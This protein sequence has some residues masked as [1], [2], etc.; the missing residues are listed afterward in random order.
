MPD[1]LSLL[2]QVKEVFSKRVDNEGKPDALGRSAIDSLD[3]WIAL[4]Q[5]GV[6][7]PGDFHNMLPLMEIAGAREGRKGSR[8]RE[9]KALRDDFFQGCMEISEN[10]LPSSAP[11]VS[12]TRA[13]EARAGA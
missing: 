4:C 12:R 1:L 11:R 3:F 9:L 7:M 10:R 2:T 8:I 13:N 6:L 5:E